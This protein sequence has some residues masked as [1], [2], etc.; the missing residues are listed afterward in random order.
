MIALGSYNGARF[1][2]AQLDSLTAQTLPRWRLVVS[3]DG[4]TDTTRDIVCPLRRVAGR[5]AGGPAAGG[6]LRQRGA[7]GPATAP[8]PVSSAGRGSS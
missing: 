3:D 7:K 8:C 2:G 6:Q 4:S 1:L 5:R